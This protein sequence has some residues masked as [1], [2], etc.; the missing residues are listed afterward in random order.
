MLRVK[1][2]DVLDIVCK[3]YNRVEVTESAKFTSFDPGSKKSCIYNTVPCET[4]S[5]QGSNYSWANIH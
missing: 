1:V 2:H 3:Y 5:S 4:F